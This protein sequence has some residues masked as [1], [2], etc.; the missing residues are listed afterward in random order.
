MLKLSRQGIILALIVGISIN[1]SLAMAEN[2]T[3]RAQ[4]GSDTQ[5]LNLTNALWG[6]YNEDL[7]YSS[8]VLNKYV[9]KNITRQE[10]LEEMTSAIVL[11]SLTMD[12]IAELNPPGKYE[13]YNENTINAFE[14]FKEYLHN[15]AKFYQTGNS[16]YA[17]EAMSLFNK[18][19]EYHDNAIESQIV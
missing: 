16:A 17:I 5:Y 15:L 9:H 19:I 12:T 1:V 18:S 8:N 13:R 4:A 6:H 3:I 7:S 14:Y 10:A 2:T 11:N